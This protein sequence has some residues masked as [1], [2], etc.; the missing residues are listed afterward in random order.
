MKALKNFQYW[1]DSDTFKKSALNGCHL[2]SK[3]ML[4]IP[5][6][7]QV[8]LDANRAEFEL[9]G[10]NIEIKLTK[11]FWGHDRYNLILSHPVSPK[12]NN[13]IYSSNNYSKWEKAQPY[14]CQTKRRNICNAKADMTRAE[15]SSIYPIAKSWISTCMTDHEDCAQQSSRSTG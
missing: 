15:I 7:E 13:A 1:L 9:W 2:C 8:F 3:F 6:Q 4:V 5:C 12:M 14:L 11:S 10:G